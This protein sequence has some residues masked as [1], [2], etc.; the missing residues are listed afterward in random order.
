MKQIT[1]TKKRLYVLFS[2]L[3]TVSHSVYCGDEKERARLNAEG[4]NIPPCPRCVWDK[5]KKGCATKAFRKQLAETV[6][7]GMAEAGRRE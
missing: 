7:A 4:A 3:E 5:L 2:I 1:I 6:T